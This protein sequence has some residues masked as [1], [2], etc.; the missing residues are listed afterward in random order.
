VIGSG[1]YI[2]SI[3]T[4]FWKGLEIML[5]EV[6]LLIIALGGIAVAITRSITRPLHR[7]VRVA[8]TV[9]AGDRTS[10]FEIEGR[11]ETAQLLTA[12]KRM[13]DSRVGIAGDVRASTDTIA[14]AS[15]QIASG[16]M[17]LSARTERQASALEQT[18]S[19][20]EELTATV[21]Q[22]AD[23][24][25]A[26]SA[27]ADCA[28]AVALKGGIVVADVV[29]KMGAINASSRKIAD[30]I[31]VIDSIA[32]QTNILALNAAVEA[33][34]AGEQG[35]GFAVVAAE[36]RALVSGSVRPAASARRRADAAPQLQ[37]A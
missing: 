12:L 13:N 6:G 22:S 9:A 32:F 17:D 36:V 24:A 11:D 15:S 21:R 1:V 27:V 31:S 33:G 25:R 28:S 18:A 10:V 26:A 3:S 16:N 5:A 14:T 8:Q 30:I 20:M 2:D 23:S 29:K 7:A 4:A 19:S 34:R 35:R 37:V